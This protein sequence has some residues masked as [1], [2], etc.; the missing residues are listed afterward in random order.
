M[1]R[2][3]GIAEG[4]GE[5]QPGR[6]VQPGAPPVGQRGEQP[7]FAI[8][9]WFRQLVQVLTQRLPDLGRNCGG[10]KPVGGWVDHAG[11]AG[12]RDGGHRG[13]QK[14]PPRPLFDY[15]GQPVTYQRVGAV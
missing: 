12:E 9:P 5:R 6:V 7:A 4:V 13:D 3:G 1:G 11:G 10:V 8:P 14:V 15:S 2:S